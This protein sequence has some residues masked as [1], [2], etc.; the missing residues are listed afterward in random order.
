VPGATNA[1]GVASATTI[2]S[3][4]GVSGYTVTVSPS[5]ILDN[6]TSV[7]ANVTVPYSTNMWVAP[8]FSRTGSASASCTMTRDWV[9]ST[10]LSSE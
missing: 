10:R 7:T 3:S 1:E 8:L 4:I 6:T 2:L 9:V 5:T